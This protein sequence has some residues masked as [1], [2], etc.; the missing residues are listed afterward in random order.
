MFFL[1]SAIF[2]SA[3][4]SIGMR[5]SEGKIKNNLAMLVMNYGMCT[6]LSALYAG[7]ELLETGSLWG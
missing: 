4:V 7:G 1:I 3:M 6:L 5:L 2:S